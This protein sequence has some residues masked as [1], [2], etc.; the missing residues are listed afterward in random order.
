MEKISINMLFPESVLKE[1]IFLI[2][3]NKADK[4]RINIKPEG[5]RK[6][7]EKTT[8]IERISGSMKYLY[9]FKSNMPYIS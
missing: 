2:K 4:K 8:N 6:A 1:I 3:I 7:K 5:F 9:P